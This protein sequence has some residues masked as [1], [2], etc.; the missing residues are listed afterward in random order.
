MAIF[1]GASINEG[2]R[3]ED[4][5]TIQSMQGN[6]NIFCGAIHADLQDDILALLS[7]TCKSPDVA[8]KKFGG[9]P[10]KIIELNC[11]SK[12]GMSFAHQEQLEDWDLGSPVILT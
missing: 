1:Y 3:M 2:G 12:P 9:T 7:S 10:P 8:L 5:A 6:A 11:L 4:E